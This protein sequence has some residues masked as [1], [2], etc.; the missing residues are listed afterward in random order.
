[1]TAKIPLQPRRLEG[2]LRPRKPEFLDLPDPFTQSNSLFKPYTQESFSIAR[3]RLNYP[4]FLFTKLDTNTALTL[5]KNDKAAIE[6]AQQSA[7]TATKAAAR[8]PIGYY[9]PD[10]VSLGIRVEV[11]AL[12]M[13]N[14]L[15]KTGRDSYLLLYETTRLFDNELDSPL[16]LQLSYLDMPV[17]DV[18]TPAWIDSNFDPG[19]D[20]GALILPTARTI[21]LTFY[22]I[23]RQ[24][25]ELIYFGSDAARMGEESSFFVR[26]EATAEGFVFIANQPAN[27]LKSFWLQPDNFPSVSQRE[28]LRLAGTP[29]QP[30][31]GMMGRLASALHLQ[32]TGDM[33][34][35]GQPGERIQFGCSQFIRNHVAPDN[36]SIN[37]STKADLNNHWVTAIILEIDRDWSWDELDVNSFTFSRSQKFRSDAA[38]GAP[39]DLGVL[40]V[41]KTAS[42][43]CLQN[44]LRKYTR[45]VF[46]DAVEPKPLKP[47]DF[48][49]ML[50]LSYTVT[51]QFKDPA[52]AT[53]TNSTYTL[54]T[55]LPVTTIPAQ[56][57][58]IA[59]AGIAL[60]K[61]V[62]KDNYST[63]ER[64]YKYLWLELEEPIA[65][66]NDQYFIRVLTYAPDPLLATF[67]LPLGTTLQEAP[68][69]IDA[70][71]YQDDFDRAGTRRFGSRCNATSHSRDCG[72]G[73]KAK[74]FYCSA[75]TRPFS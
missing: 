25:D 74:T 15:S 49:D 21:R 28:Q 39:I 27:Q 3:P 19:A 44:P 69:N 37:F 64:R 61:Y 67:I 10:V 34:L 12:E 63:T 46:F 53:P 6:A 51:V 22:A 9:D 42:R 7:D 1:M 32:L 66:P 54:T 14:L 2:I 13:D 35:A 75:A 68:F 55:E 8:R 18:D 71:P 70:E 4:A 59:A 38:F 58:K 43:L 36:S 20:S 11:K 65:D 60:S 17:L 5:L 40:P 52:L 29:D 24:D 30:Q 16:N 56:V 73:R 57:P 72:G 41:S 50:D 31:T 33:T 26:K 23:G 47:G 62:E 45:I 48:P